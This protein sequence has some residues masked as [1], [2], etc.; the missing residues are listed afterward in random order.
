[1]VY[2]DDKAGP[3][4]DGVLNPNSSALSGS[5]SPGSTSTG[6]SSSSPESSGSK[7]G[8]GTIA[9]IVVGSVTF[10]VLVGA[11]LFF[12]RRWRN[13]KY[14]KAA[15]TD[16]GGLQ[17]QEYHV[18]GGKAELGTGDPRFEMETDLNTTELPDA[19]PLPDRDTIYE[20][21]D[22]G[23]SSVSPNLSDLGQDPPGGY[24]HLSDVSN[25]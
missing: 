4:G 6:L 19:S 24:Q 14:K 25:L 9:G 5:I 2:L 17:V 15:M 11:G 1:M 22:N 21:P 8:V 16:A 3:L 13:F 18:D 23:V 12:W 20:A 7:L 10:L